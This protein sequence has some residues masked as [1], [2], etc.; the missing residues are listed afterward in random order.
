M[1]VGVSTTNKILDDREAVCIKK[2]VFFLLL[3][4]LLLDE[5]VSSQA[6]RY[7]H[8][9]DPSAVSVL[10]FFLNYLKSSD[11]WGSLGVWSSEPRN[12]ND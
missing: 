11:R 3:N 2:T 5:N 7:D 8:L 1:L 4:S 10:V 6:M 12:N 9:N